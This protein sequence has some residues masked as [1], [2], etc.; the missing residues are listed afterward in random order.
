MVNLRFIIGNF[1]ALFNTSIAAHRVLEVQNILNQSKF[2]NK[3]SLIWTTHK[4]ASVYLKKVINTI[5]KHSEFKT[6]DYSTT[7][8]SLGSRIFLDNPYEIESYSSLY[9]SHGEIYG[10]LRTPFDFEGR[11][12]FNNIFFFR[13]P[14]DLL[15]SKYYSIAF[16]HNSPYQKLTFEKFLKKRNDARSLGI[17]DFC[18]KEAE[19]WIIPYFAKF[20]ALRDSSE[21]HSIFKYDQFI[22]DPALFLSEFLNSIN[23]SLPKNVENKLIK[24]AK[25][26][27]KNKSANW[28]Y[29]S[30]YRSGKS[31]QFEYELDALTVK[32]LNKKL[33]EILIYWDFII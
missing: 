11:E 13:D 12:E 4:C 2:A 25:T 29:K 14:R 1:L 16:S 26:P 28:N 22:D 15:V 19:E 24:I 23:V 6:F 3:S 31:R 8:W 9:R 17:N 7:V 32:K 30:H 20:K 18:L 10:P 21:E 5:N 33:K 27:L